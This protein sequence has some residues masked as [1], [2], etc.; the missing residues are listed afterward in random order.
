MNFLLNLLYVILIHIPLFSW[1]NISKIK[2]LN[3]CVKSYNMRNPIKLF[4]ENPVKLY[5]ENPIKLF[6]NKY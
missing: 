2:I 4:V 6:I 1:E 5:V 3:Q